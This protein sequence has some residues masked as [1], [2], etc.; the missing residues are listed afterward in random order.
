MEYG[1]QLGVGGEKIGR[2][3][4][5]LKGQLWATFKNFFPFKKPE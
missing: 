1:E 2:G 5:F 4:G 3:R